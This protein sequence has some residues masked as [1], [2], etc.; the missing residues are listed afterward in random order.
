MSSD[1][2]KPVPA[3][4]P[5]P[6]SPGQVRVGRVPPSARRVPTQEAVTI[7]SGLPATYATTIPSVTGEVMASRSRPTSRWIP[8]LASANMGTITKLVH[9][10]KRYCSRSLGE[11]AEARP[12]RAE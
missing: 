8:V 10:C 1:T 9:G 4:A 11:I 12:R 6:V 3:T 2:V 7:P 5:V